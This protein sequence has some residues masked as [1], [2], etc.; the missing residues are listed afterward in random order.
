MYH[1]LLVLEWLGKYIFTAKGYDE[2]YW[3]NMKNTLLESVGG[4]SKIG[5]WMHDERQ[6]V[7]QISKG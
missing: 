4:Q 3:M 5:L 1:I 2:F 6:E 7:I